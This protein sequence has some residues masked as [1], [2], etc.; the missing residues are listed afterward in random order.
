MVAEASSRPVHGSHGIL[1]SASLVPPCPQPGWCVAWDPR[2]QPPAH[3]H[4]DDGQ[5]PAK[6][7]SHRGS[8]DRK[9]WQQRP[10][11]ALPRTPLS[12]PLGQKQVTPE[13]ATSAPPCPPSAPHVVPVGPW[14]RTGAP[15]A[16]FKDSA[17]SAG[18]A[19]A[20]WGGPLLVWGREG[21]FLPKRVGRVT[22][23]KDGRI[24][25]RNVR[26]RTSTRRAT[27]RS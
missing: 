18:Q 6:L 9:P 27:T 21:D 15:E 2:A 1:S 24:I 19:Q 7:L 8:W 4:T 25:Q 26:P 10:F 11:L 12:G 22:V 20:R 13:E 5:R 17:S 23:K 3:E 14:P 16:T